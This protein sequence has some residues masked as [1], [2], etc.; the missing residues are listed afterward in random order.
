MQKF[1]GLKLTRTKVKNNIVKVFNLC[2]DEH[3][4]DWYR[5]AKLHAC[6]LF[7][8]HMDHKSL[9]PSCG[10]EI[11]KVVGIIAATSPMKRWEQNLILADDFLKDGKCGHFTAVNK[12]C[13]EILD[14]D[15][16][17]TAI[18]SILGGQKTQ[19]FYMS[20]NYCSSYDGVTIDRHA[21]SIALGYRIADDSFRAMTRTQY[22]FFEEC[23]RYTAKALGISPMLL[24]SSTWQVFRERKNEFDK[25]K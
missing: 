4:N 5:E 13:Q 17:D 22:E 7:T 23:Y 12:K 24:Q 20:I 25:E 11:S 9:H 8:K 1:R 3:L 15:G 14:S 10:D 19:R 21:L 18:L 6:K 16:S 2:T